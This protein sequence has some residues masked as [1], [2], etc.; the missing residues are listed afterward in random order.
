MIRITRNQLIHIESN[1][2]AYFSLI[3]KGSTTAQNFPFLTIAVVLSERCI[4]QFEIRFS[5]AFIA[6]SWERANRLRTSCRFPIPLT[7][8]SSNGRSQDG[9]F[10]RKIRDNCSGQGKTA[11]KNNWRVLALDR[12]VRRRRWVGNS[13]QGNS[14]ENLSVIPVDNKPTKNFR[15]QHGRVINL[16]GAVHTIYS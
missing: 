15:R 9:K 7:A 1:S 5:S 11:R 12:N 10:R 13:C 8:S 4:C 3:K 2:I 14:S 16:S 6:H